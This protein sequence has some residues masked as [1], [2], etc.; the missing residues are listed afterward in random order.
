MPTAP[1]RQTAALSTTPVPLLVRRISVPVVV[2][3]F[4]QTMFN[5]VD[6]WAAGRLSTEALAGLTA[7]FPVFFLIIAISHGC[8]AATNALLSHALGA[9]DR[10]REEE[11]TRQA[12]FFAFWMSA[13][14]GGLG[15]AG[16][17]LLLREM[18]VGG[19][20]FRLSLVYLRTVFWATPFFAFAST[21]H[22]M[23]SA[24]GE[25]RPFRNALIAGFL[26]NIVFDL[27]FVFGGWGLPAMGFKGIGR[28]TV[29]IQ[30]LVA[31]YLAGVAFRRGVVSVSEFKHLHPRWRA[32][33]HL[34]RQGFPAF[35]N[36]LT[37]AVGIFVYTSFAA[38]VSTDILA[39][40]GTAMRIEQIAL[41]PA[42]GLN[43]A[44]MT[45]AGHSLGARRPDR[46]RE[47]LIACLHYGFVLFIV[48]APLV[49]IYAP[50]WMSRFTEN[51]DVVDAGTTILRISMLTFYAYVLIF[52]ITSM[53]QGLQKPIF[54]IWMGLYRQ[55]LAPLVLIPILMRALTPPELGI[56]WGAFFCVWSG[57]LLT[58]VYGLFVWRRLTREIFDPDPTP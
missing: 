22:A 50:F 9:E 12:L 39:A 2:G 38:R 8:Q 46:L 18:G 35:L 57:A 29:L 11:V 26:L 1:P 47:T 49:M 43:T 37:I 32:Q 56:W 34:M 5:V 52:V 53:L 7:S 27:W 4:F 10:A 55:V 14:I 58:I 20:T 36:L 17:P 40:F 6:T 30:L 21:L 3:M 51:S 45:L 48:G 24:H 33:R 28:A 16:A 19:E 25:T 13:A 23:L 15:W 44:A 41:L 42:I 31:A 54:A